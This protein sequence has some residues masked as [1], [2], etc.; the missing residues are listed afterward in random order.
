MSQEFS[1][2]D[3]IWFDFPNDPSKPQFTINGW[4]PALLLHDHTQPN[5]TIILSP[6]S[7]LYDKNGNEKEL[8][9][10][11]LILRKKDY[12]EL[13]HDSYVKLDQIMTFSRHKARGKYI[14]TLSDKDIASCHLKL[15]ESLQ[16]EDTIKEITQKQ[17]S[18][19]ANRI[20]EQYIK[21][22]LNQK[23]N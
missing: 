1:Q 2:G 8:K 15:M 3:I 6:L 16:M 22:F 14:C 12:P 9:S 5:Q 4:H 17:I 11:H 18:E 7:S 13:D 19:A 21:E 23:P 10:Y 20:L